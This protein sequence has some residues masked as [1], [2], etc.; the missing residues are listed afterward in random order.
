MIRFGLTNKSE[1][2]NESLDLSSH[3]NYLP[4]VR[5][6]RRAIICLLLLFQQT[7]LPLCVAAHGAAESPKGNADSY[8]KD[9]L[10][11]YEHIKA[12]PSK[13]KR[14]AVKHLIPQATELIPSLDGDSE[15]FKDYSWD[16]ED[17]RIFEVFRERI[18]E[19]SS[20]IRTFPSSQ[21]SNSTLVAPSTSNQEPTSS[22]ASGESARRTETIVKYSDE[23]A[24]AGI[25]QTM[26][27]TTKEQGDALKAAKSE[28]LIPKSKKA[29]SSKTASKLGT[30]WDWESLSKHSKQKLT[31]R[32]LYPQWNNS[33]QID[34]MPLRAIAIEFSLPMVSVNEISPKQAINP[35]VTL[36]PSPTGKWQWLDQKTLLFTPDD[37]SGLYGAKFQ[38]S[39]P[40]GIRALSGTTLS[41]SFSSDIVTCVSNPNIYDLKTPPA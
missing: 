7:L 15:E 28:I 33:Q 19:F 23:R 5:K 37:E 14:V 3:N 36:S 20:P 18:F 16:I 25:T 26:D 4:L 34:D 39:V 30:E 12:P 22:S 40:K 41:Q 21:S 13:S 32:K 17:P 2:E 27:K 9:I 8:V 38:I 35:P 24:S 6:A 1:E 31:V 11:P 10:D 29:Q